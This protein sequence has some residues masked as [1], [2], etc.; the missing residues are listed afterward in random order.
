MYSVRIIHF[1]HYV[2]SKEIFDVP[3]SFPSSGGALDGLGI[4]DRVS[5]GVDN[6]LDSTVLD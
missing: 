4:P 2:P 1:K 3:S 6:V 5:V